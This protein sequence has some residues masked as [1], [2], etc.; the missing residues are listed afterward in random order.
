ML[1]DH[2]TGP[3]LTSPVPFDQLLL[4]NAYVA[5]LGVLD[6]LLA[7]QLQSTLDR[8]P[9]VAV[10]FGAEDIW[11][12]VVEGR[13]GANLA[14]QVTTTA[15]LFP[16]F[17]VNID[18]SELEIGFQAL[19]DASLLFVDDEGGCLP[20]ESLL[21][22][23]EGLIPV[24]RF[25]AARVDRLVQPDVVETTH[26]AIRAGLGTIMMEELDKRGLRVRSV[27]AVELEDFILNFRF[28]ESPVSSGPPS[29]LFCS[30]CGTPLKPDS[31]FCVKCGHPVEPEVKP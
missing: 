9:M 7:G 25:G 27:G 15:L 3:V 26:V 16:E 28:P 22:I 10:P 11:N 21:A 20:S 2:F 4:P 18:Q 19:V 30:Q 14:W 1:Q 12:Q 8:L 17:N 23:A 31:A 5:F 6:H 13:T 24:F 29:P